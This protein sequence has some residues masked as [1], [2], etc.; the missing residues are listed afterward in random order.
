MRLP[1]TLLWVVL[2]PLA[3]VAKEP[4]DKI[5]AK[6]VAI[7]PGLKDYSADINLPLRATLGFVPYNPNLIGRYYYKRP[8]KH[9]LDLKNAPGILKKYPN[10]FGF[11]LP[12]MARYKILRVQEMNLR[13]KLPV[14]K[15][16]MIPNPRT[17]D[18]TGIDIYV[19]RSNY[20]I[21]KYDTFYVRGH[22]YVN[23]DFRK[24]DQ[25]LVYDRVSAEF[26]FPNVVATATATYSNYLFNQNLQDGFFR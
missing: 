5:L 22:L 16:A 20:T 12:D 4:V 24:Q 14:Y 26:E 6:A 3:S 8:D 21:P 25:Y 23:I 9:K 7:N 1:L 10:V 11:N 2:I 18:V 13:G 15:I 19:N 17:S